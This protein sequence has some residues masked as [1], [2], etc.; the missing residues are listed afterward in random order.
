M[1][2]KIKKAILYMIIL[3]LAGLS[4]DRL[5]AQEKLPIKLGLKVAPNMCWMN[6]NTSGYE[7]NGLSV[8]G[9]VG[10]VS[11]IYFAERYAFS[12]GLNFDF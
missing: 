7:Y 2:N 5:S 3:M 12:T 6:T 11:D 1:E 4:T 10:F 8:G 9:T